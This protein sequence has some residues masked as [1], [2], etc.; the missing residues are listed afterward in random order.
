[1]V[2]VE[3]DQVMLSTYP[4]TAGLSTTNIVEDDECMWSSS[5]CVDNSTRHSGDVSLCRVH[6]S[7]NAAVFRNIL[8]VVF[9]E[10]GELMNRFLRAFVL[11][12]VGLELACICKIKII[13]KEYVNVSSG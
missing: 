3:G 1:M 4:E 8:L 5:V 10:G 13:D 11:K 7:P 6:S 2:E 9:P 12:S